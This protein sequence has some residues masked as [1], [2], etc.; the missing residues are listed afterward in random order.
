MKNLK[1]TFLLLLSLSTALLLHGCGSKDSSSTTAASGTFTNVYTTVLST[2]CIECHKPTGAATLQD[3]VKIDFSTQALAYSTLVT[4][5]PTVHGASSVGTCA[6]A[7]LVTPSTVATS[8]LAGTLFSTYD[9]NNFAQISGCTPYA[10]HLAMTLGITTDQQTS[11]TTWIQNGA[12][13]N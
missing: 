2:A 12:Q 1:Y 4:G 3:N 11:I 8:Y 13:N 5:S 6:N 9:V 10:G 7:K